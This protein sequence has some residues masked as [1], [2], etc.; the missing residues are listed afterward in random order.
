MV[1]A[2]ERDARLVAPIIEEMF[3]GAARR[4]RAQLATRTAMQT[5][6]FVRGVRP[7]TLQQL[8]EGETYADAAVW[9]TFVHEGA[10]EPLV[11]AVEG[12]LIARLIGPLLGQ[13]SVDPLAEYRPR[14]VS[15]VELSVGVRLVKELVD[16]LE[17]NWTVGVPPRFRLDQFAPSRRVCADFDSSMP[18]AV[19]TLGFEVAGSPVGS[20][21]VGLPNALVRRLVPRAMSGTAERTPSPP[22]AQRTAQFDRVMPVEVEVVVE[23][24]R[25]H[26]P[27]RRLQALRVGDEVVLNAAGEA[28][29][30]IGDLAVFTGEPGASGGVRSI[31][32]HT[33]MISGLSS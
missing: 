11:L 22:Q 24:A 26:L 23:L 20:I 31:R 30:R 15:P 17:S 16:S 2:F 7:V 12:G 10:T 13:G 25:V 21:F 4:L 8:L 14:T 29:A 18:F 6:V 33:R 3:I 1:P 5:P 27:L 32:V 9:C 19:C 28:T